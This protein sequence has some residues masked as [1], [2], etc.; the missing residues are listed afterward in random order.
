MR[1]GTHV[2]RIEVQSHFPE[3]VIVVSIDDGENGMAER[4]PLVASLDPIASLYLSKAFLH[5]GEA[6]DVRVPTC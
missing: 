6:E 2:S 3:E 4:P 1:F 5:E